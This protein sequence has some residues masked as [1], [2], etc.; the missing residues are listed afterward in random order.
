MGA[1]HEKAVQER[2][3]LST[4]VAGVGDNEAERSSL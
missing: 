2:L 1:A 3:K 4:D